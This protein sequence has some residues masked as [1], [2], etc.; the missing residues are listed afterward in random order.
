MIKFTAFLVASISL[1]EAFITEDF[2]ENSVQPVPKG[3]TWA[4]LA[5]GFKNGGKDSF[6]GRSYVDVDLFD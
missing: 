1:G 4:N 3:S 6:T 5:W 2:S